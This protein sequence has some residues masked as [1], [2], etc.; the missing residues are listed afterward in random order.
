MFKKKIKISRTESMVVCIAQWSIIELLHGEIK[1]CNIFFKD[2]LMSSISISNLKA[3]FKIYFGMR[4]KAIRFNSSFFIMSY[5]GT[6]SVLRTDKKI[7]SIEGELLF[8]YCEDN[9]L[10]KISGFNFEVIGCLLIKK[11]RI[12]YGLRFPYIDRGEV[13]ENIAR[14]I[15]DIMEIYLSI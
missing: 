10:W 14:K 9:N 13:Q 2:S 5:T 3:K 6:Q 1:N 7:H 8:T 11:T 12:R 4:Y 15:R